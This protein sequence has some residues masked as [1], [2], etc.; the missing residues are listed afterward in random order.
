VMNTLVAVFVAIFALV[1]AVLYVLLIRPMRRMA[2]I[3]DRLSVGDMAA[4]EFPTRGPR[5]IASLVRSFN[6][7][8]KSL[9][10]ALHLLEP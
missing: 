1:N 10:K 8:R 6:R 2:L 4:P 3:A 5:E 9:D 7:M